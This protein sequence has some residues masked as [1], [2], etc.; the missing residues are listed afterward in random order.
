MSSSKPDVVSST[1]NGRVNGFS[2]SDGNSEDS[3]SY[4][5]PENFRKQ[6]IALMLQHGWLAMFPDVVRPEYFNL[7]DERRIVSTILDYHN[8]Y[9][10]APSLGDLNLL[11][12][13]D[14]HLAGD[15]I[16]L[17]HTN[18]TKTS[19]EVLEW[20]KDEAMRIAL[21]DSVK[22]YESGN[23]RKI[24]S[25]ISDAMLTGQNVI[26]V[27]QELVAG[28]KNWMES[29]NL[30]GI[31]STPWHH[32][33]RRIDGG[34]GKGELG[35]VLAKTGQLKTISLMNLGYWAAGI[36]NRQNVLHITLE[37]SESRILQRYAARTVLKSVSDFE[38]DAS[39]DKFRE[40]LYDN[41]MTKLAGKI[42]V[43]QFPSGQATVGDL[44]DYLNLVRERDGFVPGMVIVDY[45]ALLRSE[46]RYTEKRF[47]YE[48]IFVDLRGM[49][50]SLDIPIWAAAQARRKSWGNWVLTDEDVGEH[51]GISNIADL[52]I[53]INRTPDEIKMNIVRL[54]AAKVREAKGGAHIKLHLRY[55]AMI[56]SRK[57]PY[58]KSKDEVE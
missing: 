10:A 54:Y 18:L 53:S 3:R 2:G 16:Q 50:T 11:L 57:K 19:N 44:W 1:S 25:R 52:I 56:E 45:P 51:V 12:P 48:E 23:Y 21:I 13:E 37:M 26:N 39:G 27:G 58:V 8:E 24:R 33:N 35:I 32:L 40:A 4:D 20:S 38:D 15:L 7:S 17:S 41:A 6:I 9:R 31:V 36:L 49:A 43:K 30:F 42:R 29:R 46:H 22:D 47:E 55:P 34:L 14:E 28:A 5:Y